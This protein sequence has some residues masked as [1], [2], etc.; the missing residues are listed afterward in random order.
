MET[1]LIKKIV[2]LIAVITVAFSFSLDTEKAFA[3]P[4]CKNRR[5]TIEEY[6]Q[7]RNLGKVSASLR[8][9]GLK[10]V[11]IVKNDTDC[12]VPLTLD[13]N[14]MFDTILAHQRLFDRTT[15]VVGQNSTL[16]IKAD[17]PGCMSQIDL[18]LG[19]VGPENVNS[20]GHS[21]NIIMW[22]FDQNQG[23]GYSDARGNFCV[24]PKPLTVS[25]DADPN[26]VSQGGS[27]TWTAS[28]SGGDGKGTYTYSWT[29]TDDLSGNTKKINKVY[30]NSGSKSAT[31]AVT[32]G[33]KT[34]RATCYAQ[35]TQVVSPLTV[36][37]SANPSS[38]NVGDSI[39]WSAQVS[40]GNGNYVYTWSGTNSLSGN[41]SS[42]SKTYNTVGT[43]NATVSVSSGN[44]TRT[45]SC[46]A[47]ITE[48]QIPLTVSCSPSSS[49]V[50][51]GNGIYWN[52]Y[53]SGGRGGYSY[54][55]S[56]TDNLYGSG[57]SIYKNYY[58]T[59]SKSAT[60]TVSSNGQTSSA[61]CYADVFDD[62]VPPTYLEGSCSASPYNAQV[63]SNVNWTAYAYG[64][65]GN[66][67]Y[68]WTGTDN[69]Y[70]Y[71][72]SIGKTYYVPGYKTATVTITSGGRSITRTCTTNISQV[73]AYTQTDD[74]P[75]LTSVYLSD[76]P[77]TGIED[78]LQVLAFISGL[79]GFSA[80]IAYLFIRRK[81]ES[82]LAKNEISVSEESDPMKDKFVCDRIISDKQAFANVEDIAMNNK[83]I[84]SSDAVETIVKVSRINCIDERELTQKVI[85]TCRKD[86][87]KEEGD[88]CTVGNEDVKKVI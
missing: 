11:A 48:T 36:S 47:S 9:D 85:S 16:T 31:V 38:A 88:W 6:K 58:N 10:A 46:S 73:L 74:L 40:G 69:L 5:M 29:G 55:W 70:G 77:Y 50:R 18:Y 25:C 63:G 68:Y 54:S 45:A 7:F 87:G 72:S 49:S 17:L 33:D 27:I 52:A 60:V 82:V 61:I 23:S 75:T 64:G 59:G 35:V 2:V 86:K 57:S 26:R 80:L 67:S 44:T 76:I 84:L 8:V 62:Y 32:S 13:T 4:S 43:K 78:R 21:E 81:T 1:K 34:R 12:L 37:C 66:Y 22:L 56:G 39:N 30:S 3:A 65:S 28:V 14:R 51:V 24:E 42:V 20:L 71:N 79:M 41:T 19:S 15:A 53:A 83:I